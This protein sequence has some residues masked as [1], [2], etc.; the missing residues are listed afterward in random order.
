MELP[1]RQL[2]FLQDNPRLA[3]PAQQKS[4]AQIIEELCQNE[5]IEDLANKIADVGW[6]R[7]ER[8]IA[9]LEEQKHV[10]YEGNRRLC[11]LRLLLNP[12]LAPAKRQEA[13]KRLAEKAAPPRKVHVEVV[14][15]RYD[16][17]VAMYAKHAVQA[18]SKGWSPLQQAQW[19]VQQLH[20][21]RTENDLNLMG[22]PPAEI[23]HA[24]AAVD[25]FNLC[26]IAPGKGAERIRRDP[27]EFPYSVVFERLVKP[28]A[29]R[30]ALG[31]TY[32]A[33]GLT[34]PDDNKF[35][36]VLGKILDDVVDKRTVDTRTLGKDANQMDYIRTLSYSPPKKRTT[37]A[38]LVTAAVK[39][40]PSPTVAPPPP[41]GG[42]RSAVPSAKLI[43]KTVICD[44]SHSKLS[45]LLKEAK[46]L[47]TEDEPIVCAI[48]LRC[49]V[50]LALHTWL[51]VRGH[52]KMLG[53]LHKC[54]PNEVGIGLILS[55]INDGKI[56]D[57]TLDPDA[58]RALPML[59]GQ[60]G[61]L[62]Y[63]TLHLYVHNQHWSANPGHVRQMRNVLLPILTTALLK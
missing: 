58:K 45:D 5:G 13:F 60:T 54:A 33:Q 37:A 61:P 47:D 48:T 42:R 2:H 62:S 51:Q 30:A 52:H 34:V 12:T 25:F 24:A 14:P 17:E 35:M 46:R 23:E 16:A 11:A 40:Q 6:L 3:D 4:D 10:V 20:A 63:E 9:V 36:D 22:V 43:P 1:V 7:T 31:I 19:I 59:L 15:T 39:A 50:E 28:K 55:D 53:K 49:L 21:G 32:T 29:P 38:A 18:Y 56:P 27:R 57:F 26:R 44:H 41:P 8:L